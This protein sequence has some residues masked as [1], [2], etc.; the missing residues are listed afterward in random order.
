MW[1]LG[2]TPAA[3]Q[4]NAADK[5]AIRKAVAEA[6]DWAKETA[7]LRGPVAYDAR[8]PSNAADIILG[9]IPGVLRRTEE[10]AFSASRSPADLSRDERAA[11]L[12]TLF[13]QRDAIGVA[14]TAVKDAY[15]LRLATLQI[16]HE[17]RGVRQ[18]NDDVTATVRTFELVERYLDAMVT[19]LRRA[20]RGR[21]RPV[22][23]WQHALVLNLGSMWYD[24]G[25]QPAGSFTRPADRRR[26]TLG[27]AGRPEAAFP[28]V[29]RITL[30]AR[31]RSVGQR[32]S[33]AELI[34]LNL[35]GFLRKL[36]EHHERG[37]LHTL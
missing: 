12:E 32:L 13:E 4:L 33:R 14:Q 36:R 21:G 2:V 27:R 17:S 7:T 31:A 5:R 18:L 6:I 28:A 34:S 23:P 35:N 15:R 10:Q 3:L 16:K 19:E 20:R 25:W 26:T 9:E 37:T 11:R 8:L 30:Q 1:L 24:R 29:L 22:N